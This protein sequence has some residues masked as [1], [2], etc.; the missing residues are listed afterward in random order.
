G[1]GTAKTFDKLIDSLNE[2]YQFQLHKVP[3]GF[4]PSDHSSFYLRK[5]PVFFFFTGDHPDYHKPTD[6]V[7]K[8]NVAGM[9]RVADLVED[10]VGYLE[11]VAE[12]P[13]YVKV[14]RR[15]GSGM[16]MGAGPR[17]GIMPE[18]GAE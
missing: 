15:P 10:L 13:K 16:R 18:Y 1:T 17:L 2:N 7:D 3:S 14:P 12:R 8:I 11:N 4:G 9:T 6:T 5:I